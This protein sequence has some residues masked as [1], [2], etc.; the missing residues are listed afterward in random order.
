MAAKGRALLAGLGAAA[1]LAVPAAPAAA[2]PLLPDLDQ[3]APSNIGIVRV[4]TAAGK[5]W[6]LGFRSAVDNVGRGP[7]ILEGS[8]P[9]T[10]F[11]YMVADQ[12][13]ITATGGRQRFRG[14]GLLHYVKS[15]DHQHWHY[16]RFDQYE[17][18]LAATDSPVAP[19][20]KT[21]FCLG[22]RYDSGLALP[23]KPPS[24]VYTGNCGPGQPSLLSV[25]EGISVGYGD[26]YGA[27]LE[28][29]YVD[30]TAVPGGLYYLVHRVNAN[31][32]L[33]ESSTANNAASALIRI[34]NKNNKRT[35]TVLRTCPDTETCPP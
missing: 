29:Q 3:A 11:P 13:A 5:S 23:G 4:D 9:A 28:G 15:S 18:R 10:A 25:A 12:V 17:L 35:V 6:R 24:P 7:L 21:G 26:D 2:G 19:D 30:I 16:L 33:H 1:A 20:R 22:D 32:T 27:Q 8:R 31:M 14:V 34:V